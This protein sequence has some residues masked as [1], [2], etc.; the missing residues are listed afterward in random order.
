MCVTLP[1][2][3]YTSVSLRAAR[4]HRSSILALWFV[5]VFVYRQLFCSVKSSVEWVSE[6]VIPPQNQVAPPGT[7]LR[8]Y[9]LR[10]CLPFHK[11]F[12]ARRHRQVV[13]ALRLASMFLCLPPRRWAETWSLTPLNLWSICVSASTWQIVCVCVCVGARVCVWG[14]CAWVGACV[15]LCCTQVI[16]GRKGTCACVCIFYQYYRLCSII[17]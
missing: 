7:D 16:G 15:C 10:N 11:R 9:A 5:I 14:A 6:G 12:T 13:F 1:P 2:L 4:S 3:F 17:I 8:T